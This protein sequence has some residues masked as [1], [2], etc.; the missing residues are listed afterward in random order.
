MHVKKK[1][2]F[3]YPINITIFGTFSFSL[4]ILVSVIIGLNYYYNSKS[5]Y[6]TA[7]LIMEKDSNRVFMKIETLYEPLLNITNQFAKLPTFRGKATLQN[8]PAENFLLNSIESYPQIQVLYIG[9]DDGDFYEILSCQGELKETLIKTVNAPPETRFAILRQFSVPNQVE[10]SRTWEYLNDIR[11]VIGTRIE[12]YTG[13]DP[14]KRPWYINALKVQGSVKTDPYYFTNVKQMGLT[15]SH[16]IGGDSPSVIGADI[17][18]HQMALFLDGIKN[19]ELE[20][21]LIFNKDLI[22]TSNIIGL[23]PMADIKSIII[24]KIKAYVDSNGL[25]DNMN[26]SLVGGKETYLIK[27]KKLPEKYSN[28]EYLL[29]ATPRTEIMG[30][31]IKTTRRT[32]ISS[33]ILMLLSLPVF[34][35][36]SKRIS[37][38]IDK[39]VHEA[40]RISNFD[41]EDDICIQTRIKE[42]RRLT[43]EMIS[44]KR[45]IRLFNKYVPS[46]LV[47]T[48]MMSGEEAQIG[49]IS[50]KMTFL[51]TDITNFTGI[52]EKC[53]PY[54][55]MK[56]L[57]KYFDLISTI[58]RKNNGTVDK[59]IGDAVMAFWNAPL[60]DKHH[61][62][63]ACISALEIQDA[64][65]KLHTEWLQLGIEPFYTRIGVNTGEAVV[66]NMGSEDRMNY[67]AI[68]DVVNSCSRL[69]NINKNYGTEIII[70]QTIVESLDSQFIHRPL[71]RIIIKGRTQSEIIYEL[72]GTKNSTSS[73]V[74]DFARLFTEAFIFFHNQKWLEAKLIF[75]NAY[76]LKQDDLQLNYYIK[77]C[78]SFITSPPHKNWDGTINMKVT[79]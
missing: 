16:K 27:I 28:D 74:S 13:Y 7:E 23:V 37:N 45:G 62:R 38:P 61:I 15:I 52:S 32:T 35:L 49:G 76:K 41:L 9:Y 57:S 68:G 6:A 22:V 36:I 66:G 8:H 65:K 79:L 67:T 3:L 20:E 73:K 2:R 24:K 77:K 71:E 60:D 11:E 48:L 44:M 63:N 51:F 29:I 33:I 18:M 31:I 70:G 75:N 19:N 69:E 21:V 10:P 55:V 1:S 42:T 4:I 58:I 43:D 40:N 56:R 64:L 12:D 26:L 50:K 59:F 78:N 14:R 34:L 72:I 39:L 46:Q 17:L 5:A 54:D 25:Q 47:K 53:K 30:S